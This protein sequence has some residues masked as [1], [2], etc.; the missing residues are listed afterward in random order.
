MGVLGTDQKLVPCNP[1]DDVVDSNCKKVR[2]LHGHLGRV[3][4]IAWCKSLVSTGSRDR[5]ILQRDLRAPGNHFSKLIGHKQEVCGL[6]W[7]FDD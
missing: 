7:S 2:D 5:N 1:G 6:K 4:S 3:S